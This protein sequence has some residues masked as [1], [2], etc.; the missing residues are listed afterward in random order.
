MRCATCQYKLLRHREDHTALLTKRLILYKSGRLEVICPRCNG[1]IAVDG[2]LVKAMG[3]RQTVL[4]V[5]TVP[6]SVIQKTWESRI[7]RKE[8]GSNAGTDDA[9]RFTR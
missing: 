2:P 4:K 7:E 3:R 5:T 6:Q 9:Q 1:V 8:G